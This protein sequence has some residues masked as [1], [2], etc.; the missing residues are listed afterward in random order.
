[1]SEAFDSDTKDAHSVTVP[2][3]ATN[4]ESLMVGYQQ[5][6][7]S[8]A[9]LL[10]DQ[11][12]DKLYGLFLAQV[13]DHHQAEDLLQECWL[14][15]HKARH[16]WRRGEPVL[17][18]IY[19]IARRAQIDAYR[20]KQRIAQRELPKDPL[21]EIPEPA[22]EASLPELSELLKTLPPQQRE[23][24]VLLKVMGLTLEEVS[25]ATGATIGAVKQRAS[26]AYST[27]RMMFGGEA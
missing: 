4:L 6:D 27:L 16:T 1:V 21:P 19:A 14:R 7:S 22:H 17:P 15:I 26:R 24:V 3:V 12:S 8:A 18:W 2:P 10:I 23:T 5:A 25:Q 13:R 9:A 20:K 11:V